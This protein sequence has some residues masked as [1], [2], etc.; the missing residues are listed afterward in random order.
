M[1]IWD[2]DGD[3]DMFTNYAGTGM[4][5][6]ENTGTATDPDFGSES[7]LWLLTDGPPPPGFL[8]FFGYAQNT[9]IDLG[10]DGDLD[11]I[12]GGFTGITAWENIS[13]DAMACRARF[14]GAVRPPLRLQILPP[15]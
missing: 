12:M 7:V 3:W 4:S 6:H 1:W 8:F 2:C 9:W 10:G 15:V 11:Q 14:R 5:Y 13:E